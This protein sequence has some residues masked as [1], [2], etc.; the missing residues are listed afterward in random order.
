[1]SAPICSQK[2]LVTG[3][4]PTI[5]FTLSRIP[6][7]SASFTTSPITGI[8]V[9]K[10]AEQIGHKGETRYM[11]CLKVAINSLKGERTGHWIWGIEQGYNR[12]HSYCK[13]SECGMGM[14]HTEYD[15]CPNC[16]A[17]MRGNA[18]E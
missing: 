14:G 5:I 15:F 17:D 12:E 1:M 9:V 11:K 6:A 3:A 13:C 16:G 7:F 10:R 8:V 4:P 2:V 18:D